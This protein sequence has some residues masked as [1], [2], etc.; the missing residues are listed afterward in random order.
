VNKSLTHNQHSYQIQ[1]SEA[2]HLLHAIFEM[3]PQAAA[4]L[5]RSG[6][7][8]SVNA[9]ATLLTGYTTEEFQKGHFDQVIAEEDRRKV[10]VYFHQAFKGVSQTFD[11]VIVHKDGHKIELSTNVI[12]VSSTEKSTIQTVVVLFKD[13]TSEKRAIER[14]KYMAY[15]DDMTGIPNRRYF[16]DHLESALYL[17]NWN[18]SS[19]AVFYL[20]ID[21]FKLFNDSLGHD[22][23]N[24]LLLQVAERLNR[25]VSSHD[26]LARMEGDEF[27]IFYTDAGELGAIELLAKKLH[28][29]MEQT[30]ECQGHHLTI[31]VSI[32]ISLSHEQ[33]RDTDELMK[34]ADIALSR[35]KELGRNNYQFYSVSMQRGTLDRLTLE[36]DLRAAIKQNEFELYY[37]PQVNMQTGKCIG[38][39]G[40]IRWNHPTKGLIMPGD[41]IALAEENGMIVPIGEKVIETACKQAVEWQRSGLPSIPVSVNLSVRQFLQPNLTDRIGH[42]LEQTGLDPC[43]LELEITESVNSDADYAEKVLD[44]LK[45]LGVE[46]CIDDFGTGYSSLN[47]LRRFPISR[48]KIDRSFV[49]D[50]MTDQNDAQ[51]VETIIAMARH[52]GMKVIAEG[53]ENEDQLR[54]LEKHHCFEIQG[55]FFARPMNASSMAEWLRNRELEV[56]G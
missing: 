51:I 52:L 10:L 43:L 33:Y 47:Y 53:V 2:N 8:Q 5:N 7:F 41:F 23:G 25:C 45:Q 18:R 27:A 14:I 37:Q 6:K 24:M 39:E 1:L 9:S 3:N 15:Y 16:R 49:R 55:Y 13:V 21:R 32:G 56:T 44:E 20:D 31:T 36:A 38:V 26:V 54:F 34:F 17:A 48:L 29:A 42:I 22:V 50:V 28:A 11:M 4:I 30:F 46:I 35:A 12:P 40:L 19:I